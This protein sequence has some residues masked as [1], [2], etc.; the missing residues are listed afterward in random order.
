S[1][2]HPRNAFDIT[3]TT[4]NQVYMAGNAA[5]E[6]N[7]GAPAAI[8]GGGA[9]ASTPYSMTNANTI[10][11]AGCQVSTPFSIPSI[12]GPCVVDNPGRTTEWTNVKNRAG[13]D[14][15]AHFPDN[16]NDAATRA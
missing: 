5:L 12:S 15:V 2:G 8:Q 7:A 14:P 16:A 10:S 9:P 13:L 6:N 11:C 1:D 4:L 3:A